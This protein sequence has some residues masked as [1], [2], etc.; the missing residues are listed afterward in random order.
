MRNAL[1]ALIFLAGCVGTL[2]FPGFQLD[3]GDD[4]D[5]ASDDDDATLDDDDATGDDDDATPIGGDV[6]CGLTVTPPPNTT[7]S[8]YT[9]GADWAFDF[10]GGD[11]LYEVEW[12]GCEVEHFWDDA[13]EVLCA[14]E[15]SGVG[16]AYVAQFQSEQLVIRFEVAWTLQQNTCR[17]NHPD[18]ADR[19]GFYRVTVPYEDGAIVILTDP[20]PQAP[21]GQMTPWTTVPYTGQGDEPDDFSLDYATEF[22]IGG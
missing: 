17:N 2:E 11:L 5:S 10:D 7:A 12:D 4:D 18:A 3:S 15:W 16:E 21:A 8:A 22:V 6:F 19:T 9:G 14:I 13:G 20:D 1:L